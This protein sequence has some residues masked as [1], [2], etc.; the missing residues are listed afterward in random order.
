LF[1]QTGKMLAKVTRLYIISPF[2]FV[3]KLIIYTM[4]IDSPNSYI[5]FINGGTHPL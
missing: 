4:V 5:E 2:I 1:D 3:V